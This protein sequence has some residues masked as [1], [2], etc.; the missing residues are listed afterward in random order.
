M[1]LNLPQEFLADMK[2]ML[3]EEW[4]SFVASYDEPRYRGIRLN[5]LKCDLSI[6]RKSLPFALQPSPFAETSFYAGEEKLG[7]LPAH[8]AGMFYGQEPS[9]SSAVTVL[10]PEPGE[11]ILDLCAAPGGKSTQIAAKLCGK[12]L[13]WSN[14]IIGSRASVLLSNIE[15]MGVRNAV[16]SSVHPEKLCG[17]LQGYFDRVLVDAPCSGEGMFKKEPDAITGWSRKNVIA[18]AQRQQSILHSAA[19]AVKFGGVLVYST[20]TF[21]KEE[22][23]ETIALFLREHADFSLEPID[24]PFGRLAF[25]MSA[26][27]IF[28]MDKGEGHFVCKMRRIE[29]N[30]CRAGEFTLPKTKEDTAVIHD[31]YSKALN[32]APQERLYFSGEKVFLLPDILPETQGLNILR[33]GVFLGEKKLKRFEP[34][35]AFFMSR[36]KADCRQT[37]DLP[38]DSPLLNA[39]L[40]GEEI[41]AETQG[42]TA[43]CVNGVITG[44]GKASGGRLKNKYP[45]GLRLK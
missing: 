38:A 13:L 6:L 1:Q 15:R 3:G 10:A 26:L 14:E 45:K 19:Q 24:V 39:F 29:E 20:C 32:L 12:G 7:H 37:I 16:V 25:G 9:A 41:P 11:K 40:R 33:A 35:H 43:M 5:T 17:T 4:Q 27:R 30:S 23:E 22:N 21:S 36:H 44:F 28:P 31:F 18:C 42:Y 2:N 8:H 34:A